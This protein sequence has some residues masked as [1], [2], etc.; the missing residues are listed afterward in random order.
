MGAYKDNINL[1]N[2]IFDIVLPFDYQYKDE[3][4][5]DFIRNKLSALEGNFNGVINID[6]GNL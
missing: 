2:I 6:K 5:V 4:V 3:Y 1:T